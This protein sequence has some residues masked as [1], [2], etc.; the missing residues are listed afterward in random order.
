MRKASK[1]TALLGLALLIGGTTPAAAGA[2]NSGA[3]K[4]QP[5]A[6]S[7]DG[8]PGCDFNHNGIDDGFLDHTGDMPDPTYVPFD[9]RLKGN[10]TGDS[11]RGAY[12]MRFEDAHYYQNETF[13]VAP[14]GVPPEIL[15]TG[16]VSFIG[17]LTASDFS[18][19]RTLQPLG[20]SALIVWRYELTGVDGTFIARTGGVIRLDLTTGELDVLSSHGPCEQP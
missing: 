11:L 1:W 18:D 8:G 17:T 15:V 6:L 16:E 14:V 3:S 5:G 20:E 2:G 10:L 9:Y 19:I 12:V 13:P 7:F 4:W